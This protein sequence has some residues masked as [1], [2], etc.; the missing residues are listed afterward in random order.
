M[1]RI[2]QFAD[3]AGLAVIIDRQPHDIA[4]SAR[5]GIGCACGSSL[6]LKDLGVAP[7]AMAA[8]AAQALKD[9]ID[10]CRGKIIIKSDIERHEIL[11]PEDLSL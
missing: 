5:F 8:T 11:V 10:V 9:L 7:Q 6:W 3:E 2:E 4:W 1:T